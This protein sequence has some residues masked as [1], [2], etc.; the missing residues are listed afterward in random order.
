MRKLVCALCGDP[1]N[2]DLA[3]TFESVTGWVSRHGAKNFRTEER[4]GALAHKG[5][6]DLKKSGHLHQSNLFD[7]E[8]I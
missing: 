1:I 4:T 8:D 7:N 5:C 6:L 2:P 3:S